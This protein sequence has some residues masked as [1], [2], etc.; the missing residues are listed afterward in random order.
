VSSLD[1]N[2]IK[3]QLIRLFR[4]S[5]VRRWLGR[6]PAPWFTY[7]AFIHDKSV[8]SSFATAA[9]TAGE[10]GWVNSLFAAL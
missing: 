9:W 3:F 5:I 10:C 4:N 6:G 1:I 8:N 2:P 7:M